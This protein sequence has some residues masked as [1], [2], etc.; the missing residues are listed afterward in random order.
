MRDGAAPCADTPFVPQPLV[1]AQSAPWAGYMADTGDI[2]EVF[3][4][5][6][7]GAPGEGL[8]A[9]DGHGTFATDRPTWGFSPDGGWISFV[10]RDGSLPWQVEA[11]PLTD[12][13]PG[14][15]RRVSGPF[16]V[17][18]N[19]TWYAWSPDGRKIAYVADQ[20]YDARELWVLDLSEDG[21]AQRVNPP[22][23]F[24]G[25]VGPWDGQ[26]PFAWSPDSTRLLYSGWL[27][28]PEEVDL[29]VTDVSGPS[30]APAVRLTDDLEGDVR[31]FAWSP[32]G[33]AVSFA[34]YTPGQGLYVARLSC[35]GVEGPWQVHAS[36]G[37]EKF[38]ADGD[39]LLYLAPVDGDDWDEVAVHRADLTV[40]PPVSSVAT[41]SLIL[42]LPGQ[43]H[44]W[45]PIGERLAIVTGRR[46][47]V[48]DATTGLNHVVNPPLVPNGGIRFYAWSPDG[49]SIAYA[50]NQD[51][52]SRVELY[53]VDMSGPAPALK[54]KVSPPVDHDVQVDSIL[55]S[56]DST[57]LAYRANQDV[58]T[59]TE[60]YAGARA[61]GVVAPPVKLNA[62]LTRNGAE[63]FRFLW[64]PDSER[65]LYTAND[66]AA[67]DLDAFVAVFDDPG[68]V[69][70]VGSGAEV[71]E[72]EWAP[73]PAP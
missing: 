5:R 58:E 28:D 1:C 32:D 62:D 11:A 33:R 64:S 69:T 65:M 41:E 60:I 17:D 24:L 16:K 55:W 12:E 46:L 47:I 38:G 27:D 49:D 25:G 18:G 19:V 63:I 13:G 22:L 34:F 6:M 59:R 52:Y 14:E 72:I 54:R 15:L 23:E 51:A 45:S 40:T 68:Q 71:R 35:A 36:A 30:P 20:A 50:A 48:L 3:V 66:A 56:P 4:V 67:F 29:Y 26:W 61:G 70:P 39:T 9:G 8:P 42:S 57:R 10:S 37:F 2:D 43:Q 44:Q 7:A 73:C 21:Y 31:R 53:H